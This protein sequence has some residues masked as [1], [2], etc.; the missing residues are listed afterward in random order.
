LR[1]FAGASLGVAT[2]FFTFFTFSASTSGT[3]AIYELAGE[4]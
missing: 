3:E 2:A 4:K 1:F